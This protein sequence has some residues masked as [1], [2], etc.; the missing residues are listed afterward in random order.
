MF[1]WLASTWVYVGYGQTNAIVNVEGGRIVSQLQSTVSLLLGQNL[2]V[3][4]DFENLPQLSAIENFQPP[5]VLNSRSSGFPSIDYYEV[6]SS[7][8]T[9]ELS[10]IE[11]LKL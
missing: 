1:A 9:H 3:P 6:A 8:M 10:Q 5:G 7:T 2:V 4:V 11:L